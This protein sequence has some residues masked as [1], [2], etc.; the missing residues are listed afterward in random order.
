MKIKKL[1]LNNRVLQGP[2]ISAW[3]QNLC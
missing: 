3:R 1:F 2:Q